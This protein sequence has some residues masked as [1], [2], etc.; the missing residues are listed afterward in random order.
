MP[1]IM[2]QPE[3]DALAEAQSTSDVF[4]LLLEGGRWFGPVSGLMHMLSVHPTAKAFIRCWLANDFSTM[5][6]EDYEYA[7]PEMRS[8]AAAAKAAASVAEMHGADR[9][10]RIYRA[11]EIAFWNARGRRR[12][13]LDEDEATEGFQK[14]I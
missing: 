9:E 6:D 4:T 1:I 11:I 14:F 10:A 5:S 13:T 7:L 2:T 12:P 3:Y 8:V